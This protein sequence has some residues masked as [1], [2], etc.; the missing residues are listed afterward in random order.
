[1]TRPTTDLATV[2]VECP[3]CGTPAAVAPGDRRAEDFC[4]TCD[5]PLF[6]AGGAVPRRASVLSDDA[7][8]RLPGTAGVGRTTGVPCPTCAEL[9]STL[10]TVCAR[11]SGPM[12]LPA[13]PAPVPI[14][15]PVP[16]ASEP[17]PEPSAPEKVS[18]WPITI[19][20]AIAALAC[21]G[22]ALVL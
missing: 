7:L 12:E 9:N 10:A 2:T 5:E 3:A 1:M 19:A 16:V 13:P 11:C 22:V 14:A 15:A 8:R 18:W 20:L 4:R 17:V 21:L 6:W